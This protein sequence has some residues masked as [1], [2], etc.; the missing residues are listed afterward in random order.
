VAKH[1]CSPGLLPSCTSFQWSGGNHQ[2]QTSCELADTPIRIAFQL[3]KVE[4]NNWI[5]GSQRSMVFMVSM[6]SMV[7][8]D[9][10]NVPATLSHTAQWAQ[11]TWAARPRRAFLVVCPQPQMVGFSEPSTA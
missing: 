6:V 5:T 3:S 2:A 7:I 10:T 4:K 8:P 11:W 9:W 1:E